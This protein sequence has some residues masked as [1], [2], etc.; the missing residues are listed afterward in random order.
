MTERLREGFFATFVVACLVL[1]GASREGILANFVLQVCAL[2]FLFWGLYRLQL[3]S[4]GTHERLLLV[5][6]GLGLVIIGLQCVPL[7]PELWRQL[8]GRAEIG[9]ELDL[10]S[11]QPDPALVTFSIHESLRS[12]IAL[13]PA[14]AIAI[15][16]MAGRTLPAVALAVAIAGTALLSLGVGM[17]QALGGPESPWYFYSFTNRGSMVGF[18]ANA[19]HMATLLLVALPFLAA[20][21][22]DARNRLPQRRLELTILGSALFALIAMGVSLVGSL[23]GYALLAPVAFASA[24]IVWT[25]G[26]RVV[27]LMALPV[28]VFS[29][30]ILA[31]M[32]DEENAFS[33]EA[34]N[35]ILGREQIRVNAMAA[36]QD[37]FPVGSGLGTF[38]EVY[39]RYEDESLVGRTFINHA[40]NDYLEL[41]V[42]L[43]APGMALIVL[44]I[45][46]WLYCLRRLI[47]G[48]ASPYAWAGWIA[49]GVFLTHSGWDY[50]LRTTALSTLFAIACVLTARTALPTQDGCPKLSNRR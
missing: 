25:P 12:A 36:A 27:G 19:N 30:S 50:P 35:S 29:G 34:R 39:R 9:A 15:A 7:S 13:L 16:L 38:E 18:F 26:K 5:L 21:L 28:L 42:E 24:L 49:L 8:P 33:M 32:G 11:V 40:H 3:Q 6:G 14:V 20:L 48:S 2:G 17:M 31:V 46:W 43:G 44:F 37:F 10:L 41:I 22:R 47:T 45:C 1:G 4:L 23:T